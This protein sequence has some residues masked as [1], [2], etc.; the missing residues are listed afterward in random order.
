MQDLTLNWVPESLKLPGVKAEVTGQGKLVAFVP[1]P[2]FNQSSS[3]NFCYS[4]WVQSKVF[5]EYVTDRSHLEI[6]FGPTFVLT[7]FCRS[8][9]GAVYSQ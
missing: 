4:N 5:T 2:G 8:F 3:T 1:A 7:S 6:V 9:V